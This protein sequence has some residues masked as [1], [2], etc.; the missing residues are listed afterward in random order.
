MCRSKLRQVAPQHDDLACTTH[1]SHS[2]A[3]RTAALARDPTHE[4]TGCEARGPNI[5]HFPV[6]SIIVKHDTGL[7]MHLLSSYVCMLSVLLNNSSILQ[8]QRSKSKLWTAWRAFRRSAFCQCQ[9]AR[10][11]SSCILRCDRTRPTSGNLWQKLIG[12]P[13]HAARICRSRD[14]KER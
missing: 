12:K 5:E 10:A 3:C 11:P 7:M 2:R 1:V 9:G 13:G 8:R 6:R 14:G 4:P